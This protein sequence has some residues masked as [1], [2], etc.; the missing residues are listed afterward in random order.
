M[1]HA[2]ALARNIVAMIDGKQPDEKINVEPAAIHMT[3]G[4]VQNIV[5]RNPNTAG[6]D[7]E[8]SYRFR[9]E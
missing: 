7:T 9:D 4:L 2:K 6:G 3:M 8:P 1:Q 5:F